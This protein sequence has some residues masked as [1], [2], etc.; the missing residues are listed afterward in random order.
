MSE[1]ATIPDSQM[2]YGRVI[3]RILSTRLKFSLWE[4]VCVSDAVRR[5]ED[6]SG[7]PEKCCRL[8]GGTLRV[9]CTLDL[10]LGARNVQ[11]DWGVYI[12]EWLNT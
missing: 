4:V 8:S 1:S 11:A 5:V 10:H 6:G 3:F 12:S 7:C 9:F 2:F